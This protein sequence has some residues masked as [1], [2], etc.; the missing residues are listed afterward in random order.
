MLAC[1]IQHLVGNGLLE[2]LQS[3][4]Q[5]KPLYGNCVV[6][7]SQR[8]ASLG[9]WGEGLSAGFVGSVL[10]ICYQ[11]HRPWC[12]AEAIAW[13]TWY[14]RSSL[15]LV[16]FLSFGAYPVRVFLWTYI[17]ATSAFVW[18]TAGLGLQPCAVHFVYVTS[19]IYDKVSWYSAPF[20]ML[21]TLNCIHLA[22]LPNLM[23]CVTYCL[24]AWVTSKTGQS[25]TNLNSVRT[26][27]RK[28]RYG[29]CQHCLESRGIQLFL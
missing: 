19:G 11:Y 7:T 20:F 16:P 15:E 9:R 2:L 22:L 1:F 13:H 5:S 21:T 3:A 4:Y 23:I 24:H 18:C 8:P 17:S 29:S 27:W 14:W 26:R 28:W 25:K 12:F 10:R 6:E